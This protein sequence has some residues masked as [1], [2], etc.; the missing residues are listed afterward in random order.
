MRMTASGRT[1]SFRAM[2][3]LVA[4]SQHTFAVRVGIV[5]DSHVLAHEHLR[6]KCFSKRRVSSQSLVTRSEN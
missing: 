4:Q 3:C 2:I 6:P 1:A 5:W